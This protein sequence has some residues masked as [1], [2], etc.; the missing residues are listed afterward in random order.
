MRSCTL[1]LGP[2]RGPGLAAQHPS[3]FWQREALQTINALP[4]VLPLK[5]Q[6]V[7]L[8]CRLF[9]WQIPAGSFAD[10]LVRQLAASNHLYRCVDSDRVVAQFITLRRGLEASFTVWDTL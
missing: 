7:G 5:R 4:V 1:L 9:N 6:P 2:V 10:K 8:L 3:G